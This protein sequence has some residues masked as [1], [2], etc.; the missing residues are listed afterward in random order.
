MSAPQALEHRTTLL[1]LS[2]ARVLGLISALRPPQWAQIR[3]HAEMHPR[4]PLALAP[5]LRRAYRNERRHGELVKAKI[6]IFDF[7][8]SVGLTAFD[9]QP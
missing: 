6:R 7:L 1:G 5:P 9:A 2:H 3:S 4:S 8:A